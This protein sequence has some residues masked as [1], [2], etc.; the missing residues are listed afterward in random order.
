MIG[1]SRGF[2]EVG[3]VVMWSSGF[4]GARLG[5]PE[6]GTPTLMAW[7]FLLAAGLLLVGAFLL[8]RRLPDLQEI[9]VQSVVGLLAQGVYLTGVV[10]AVEFGV[11]AGTSALV[12]AL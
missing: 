2:A 12:A 11:T 10:G 7:R 1:K 6:A 5:T 8:Q 9:A 3:F 4:I